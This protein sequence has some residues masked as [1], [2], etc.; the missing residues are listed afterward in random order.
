MAL[1]EEYNDRFD[2]PHKWDCL[3]HELFDMIQGPPLNISG[4]NDPDEF[5]P[6]DAP[7]CM[8]DEYKTNRALAGAKTSQELV[9]SYRNYYSVGKKHLHKYTK[10]HM[11]NWVE[12]HQNRLVK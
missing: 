4:L 7:V 10:R 11:P 3:D 1:L 2:K 8:P 5:D 9:F 12:V 6:R